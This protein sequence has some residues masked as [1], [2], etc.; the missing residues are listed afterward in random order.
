MKKTIN[1]LIPIVIIFTGSI[2]NHV[3]YIND[4]TNIIISF[5]LGGVTGGIATATYYFLSPYHNI[6]KIF[7]D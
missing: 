3:L 1:F 7:R 6:Y 5:L 4:S 2:I